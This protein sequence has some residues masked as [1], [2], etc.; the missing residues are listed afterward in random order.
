MKP[1]RTFRTCGPNRELPTGT[2]YLLD[3]P[4]GA[5]KAIFTPDGHSPTTHFVTE[6]WVSEMP[7]VTDENKFPVGELLIRH[8]ESERSWHFFNELPVAVKP[9]QI[10]ARIQANPHV[11]G[12]R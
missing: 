2:V 3:D 9:H 8:G 12:L 11:R 1:L 10:T 5:T 6:W 4:S 7:S